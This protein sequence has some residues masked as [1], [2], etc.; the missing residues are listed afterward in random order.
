MDIRDAGIRRIYHKIVKI[1]QNFASGHRAQCNQKL[2][3]IHALSL[4]HDI[5]CNILNQQRPG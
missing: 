4:E 5:T 1:E 3:F 2:S